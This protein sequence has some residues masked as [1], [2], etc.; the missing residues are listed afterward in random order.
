[1][2]SARLR[3]DTI[4]WKDVR[5]PGISPTEQIRVTAKITDCV[6]APRRSSGTER[7]EAQNSELVT[8]NDEYSVRKGIAV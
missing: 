1:M 7:R 8:R 3:N 6:V 4:L 5:H 2:A